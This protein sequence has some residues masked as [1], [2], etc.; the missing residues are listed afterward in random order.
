MDVKIRQATLEDKERIGYFLRVA[1]QDRAQ[2]KFPARWLW[3]YVDN[4]FWDGERLP[5]WIAEVDGK[6]VA[7]NCSMAVPLKLG[8]RVYQAAWGADLIVLQ[9]IEVEG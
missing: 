3:E 4:P 1:Y 6:I 9:S 7:Q 2:Y 8:D 5:I